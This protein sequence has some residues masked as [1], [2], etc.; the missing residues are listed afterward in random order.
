MQGAG[1]REGR[2]A[3]YAPTQH[4]MALARHPCATGAGSPP[5]TPTPSPGRSDG[6]E[7]LLEAASLGDDAAVSRLLEQGAQAEDADGDDWTALVRAAAAGHE[8]IVR[9]LLD[10]GAS[11]VP[12]LARGQEAARREASRSGRSTPLHYS[13]L[14]GETSIVNMLVIAADTARPSAN[15][16]PAAKLLRRADYSRV[17]TYLRALQ[18]QASEKVV[19]ARLAAQPGP[20][21]QSSAPHTP[22]KGV[23]SVS[24]DQFVRDA[25]ESV[26]RQV[27]LRGRSFPERRILPPAPAL[28]PSTPRF[29]HSLP[30]S[31]VSVP[32]DENPEIG[33][34][35]DVQAQSVL[36]VEAARARPEILQKLSR[37]HE[38]NKLTVNCGQNLERKH[39]EANSAENSVNANEG[40]A[41][42]TVDS[43][44]SYQEEANYQLTRFL[45][46]SEQGA[47]TLLVPKLSE[48][49]RTIL[50][51]MTAR[52]L[53]NLAQ[54]RHV[55][56]L[57]CPA[58]T[59]QELQDLVKK[60][61]AVP[62][63]QLY[64]DL[65]SVSQEFR[66]RL[67]YHHRSAAVTRPELMVFLKELG[68]DPAQY[69]DK[70]KLVKKLTEH[71]AC[72]ELKQVM[73][74][75]KSKPIART[76]QE[77]REEPAALVLTHAEWVRKLEKAL[78][79]IA[80][81]TLFV[82]VDA[83]NAATGVVAESGD[84]S[85]NTGK[86]KDGASN[87]TMIVRSSSGCAH[88]E[89]ATAIGSVATSATQVRLAPLEDGH[90]ADPASSVSDASSAAERRHLAYLERELGSLV[91]D[92][93]DAAATANSA[94]IPIVKRGSNVSRATEH[95]QLS[96]VGTAPTAVSSSTAETSNRSLIVTVQRQ[97]QQILRLTRQVEDLRADLERTRHQ[98]H[99]QP[100]SC[101]HETGV[102]ACSDDSAADHKREMHSDPL[103]EAEFR[104][105][106]SKNQVDQMKRLKKSININAADNDGT[107]HIFSKTALQ[108]F[109]ALHHAALG[110][111][112]PSLDAM[113][114]LLQW[115][116]KTDIEDAAGITARGYAVDPRAAALLDLVATSY[117][118]REGDPGFDNPELLPNLVP[119]MN[120][121]DIATVLISEVWPARLA[122]AEQ[123]AA[124]L[125]A[126]AVGDEAALVA[127]LGPTDS[128]QGNVVNCVDGFGQ[129]PLCWA[130]HQG[131]KGVVQRLLEYNADVGLSVH[132]KESYNT[133]P[134]RGNFLSPRDTPFLNAC[135]E[136]H[137]EIARLLSSTGVKR[138]E[139]QHAL[140]DVKENEGDALATNR[141]DVFCHWTPQDLNSDAEQLRINQGRTDVKRLLKEM[142]AETYN[143]DMHSNKSTAPNARL[144]KSNHAKL[145]RKPGNASSKTSRA[146][147][148]SSTKKRRDARVSTVGP[149]P[150]KA[151]SALTTQS[152]MQAML[153][154][155]TTPA[156]VASALTTQSAMQAMLLSP[157]TLSTLSDRRVTELATEYEKRALAAAHAAAHGAVAVAAYIR[158]NGT[159]PPSAI[160]D[161]KPKPPDQPHA[162]SAPRFTKFHRELRLSS[163]GQQVEKKPSTTYGKW[164]TALCA[165]S[166]MVMRRG[167]GGVPED[168]FA[169]FLIR[170]ATAAEKRS[171]EVEGRN[172]LQPHPHHKTHHHH[173]ALPRHITIG[174][175][176][177]DHNPTTTERGT[178]T[179]EC[180][181]YCA[182]SGM[183][184]H[185]GR[186][187]D[188]DGRAAAVP[189]DTI[190]LHLRLPHK[191]GG[192][193]SIFLNGELLGEMCSIPPGEYV[194]MVENGDPGE[195]VSVRAGGI[196]SS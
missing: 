188:W 37:R 67:H 24:Y 1:C 106:A 57:D 15:L 50:G 148:S 95:Q 78:G 195:T 91:T 97:E 63:R 29:K 2:S 126:A 132:S 88:D 153:L 155:P 85:C 160:N 83:Q 32:P 87:D 3:S 101:T 90:H 12:L 17:L 105:A 60:T 125:E 66:Q 145:P 170:P 131:H 114:L 42:T 163:D 108:G 117:S 80:P 164:R 107:D 99:L 124:V 150:A 96:A 196:R 181:G 112:G 54:R 65:D 53:V 136:G 68:A 75:D 6:P 102:D 69:F 5:L 39:R 152:A 162:G 167:G 7:T 156:E 30:A 157:T 118:A 172:G 26:A 169:D 165:G 86:S 147:S 168:Y 11:V 180:W 40:S 122:R 149:T 141:W 177:K 110:E 161:L 178:S 77:L 52:Q 31:L 111:H 187:F 84:N 109:T 92:A 128:S 146:R 192:A 10:H 33:Q 49:C 129:T 127:A 19:A 140:V 89:N 142:L 9:I 154:S 137:S 171:G 193:L 173:R 45:E 74:S 46:F 73:L 16:E 191:G 100:A 184:R 58:L 93:K 14:F 28:R 104:A 116:C 166:R 35:T 119:A 175:A 44:R 174:V 143:I 22:V 79:W 144:I 61:A 47:V 62:E 183:C 158:E 55:S 176:Q 71:W 94:P 130:A 51:A 81:G 8:A 18:P 59:T 121:A 190:G 21:P 13:V 151:A 133:A 103:A 120:P 38:E 115:G 20:T 135:R 159:P 179:R 48:I 36:D 134:V 64:I 194:W 56:V 23:W 34:L 4:A 27:L 185:A 70:Q 25:G 72:R 41:T 43:Q 186:T 113:I 76:G 189:G 123:H 182:H 139:L 98:A 138:T 82:A